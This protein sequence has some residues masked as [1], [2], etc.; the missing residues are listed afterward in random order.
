MNI[1]TSLP[2]PGQH[3]T[4]PFMLLTL[5]HQTTIERFQNC[6]TNWPTATRWASGGG[7]QSLRGILGNVFLPNTYFYL[8]INPFFDHP[9]YR[10]RFGAYYRKVI[11]SPLF[12]EGVKVCKKVM[13][14]NHLK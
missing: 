13:R 3:W 6:S 12:G 8:N 14:P 7:R 10:E 5:P 4:E 11:N 1:S 9:L 2:F